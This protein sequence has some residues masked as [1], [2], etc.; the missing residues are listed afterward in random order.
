MNHAMEQMRRNGRWF[1]ELGTGG[2]AFH[3]PARR[4]YEQLGFHAVP[5]V[6]YMRRL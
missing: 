5:L 1:V 3:A 4:L 2:D 6:A